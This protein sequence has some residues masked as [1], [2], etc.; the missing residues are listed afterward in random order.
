MGLYDVV[1]PVS[2]GLRRLAID[3]RPVGTGRQKTLEVTIGD[4]QRPVPQRR[5]PNAGPTKQVSPSRSHRAGPAKQV[6]PSRSHQAGLTKQV[7]PSRSHQAGPTKCPTKQVPRSVP[8]RG[9]FTNSSSYYSGLRT[10]ATVVFGSYTPCRYTPR[11]TTNTQI[12]FRLLWLPSSSV[13]TRR[14]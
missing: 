3:C 2:R 8:Q 9:V 14:D 12:F 7:S 10:Q 11:L 1:V 5:S 6:S 4:T 13:G